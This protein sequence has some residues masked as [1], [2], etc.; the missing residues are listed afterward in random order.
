M[1]PNSVLFLVVH[2]PEQNEVCIDCV[3][4]RTSISGARRQNEN[5]STTINTAW[6][7]N[8]GRIED[9]DLVRVTF[10]DQDNYVVEI[11]N[12]FNEYNG[13]KIY[14]IVLSQAKI[15]KYVDRR[16]GQKRWHLY[17][18]FKQTLVLLGEFSDSNTPFDGED[19][20]F[21]F[22]TSSEEGNAFQ[23]VCFLG[24][25][26]IVPKHKI[27]IFKE[28]ILCGGKRIGIQKLL[29][30]IDDEDKKKTLVTGKVLTEFRKPRSLS[31]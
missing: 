19:Q 30:F 7:Q 16:L 31:G 22:F 5:A 14:H 20:V 4:I 18:I 23:P 11:Y 12:Y 3:D 1:I 27:E 28:E 10:I 21:G 9:G 13:T 2:K 26:R 8:I 17:G 25:N 6:T 29:D 24:E 15:T